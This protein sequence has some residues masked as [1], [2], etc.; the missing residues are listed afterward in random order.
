MS[1]VTMEKGYPTPMGVSIVGKD[2]NI[3]VA[4]TGEECS[5]ILY[6]KATGRKW[7]RLE[8]PGEYRV[9]NV[10]CVL[11]KNFDYS[12]VEY[13]F[14]SEKN[15]FT[16]P[17][18]KKVSG[19]EKWG[20][21]NPKGVFTTDSFDFEDDKPLQ[22]PYEDVILYTLHVRGFTK[23][24]SSKVKHKGTFEGM[25]EKIPYLKDLGIN[26]VE[27]MPAYEFNELIEKKEEKYTLVNIPKDA[28]ESKIFQEEMKIKKPDNKI[29]FWGYT[30]AYYFA[31]KSSYSAVDSPEIS[32][33]HM[34]KEFHKA[35]I[36]IIMQFYFPVE[37]NLNLMIDCIRYWITE[38]HID[39]VHLKGSTVPIE[40]I[41]M[42]PFLS[43]SKISY[44]RMPTEQIYQQNYVPKQRNLAVCDDSYM[45]DIR[46][47]LKSDEDMLRTFI[48]HQLCNPQKHVMV[49][50]LTNY[51]GFTLMDLVSYDR[52]HN[53][54]NGEDNLDGNEYNYS[55]NCGV[56][57]IS[58]RKAI[59]A[60]REKQIKNAFTFLFLSQGVPMIFSGDEFGRTQKGNNNA[61]CQDNEITWINWT[62]FD[63]N[64]EQWE[65]V[66][67]MISF[68]KSHSF[69]HKRE[70]FQMM[71]YKSCGFPDLSY[72]GEMVW[73]PKFEN[74]NR[75]IGL[76]YC[77]DYAELEKGEKDDSFYVAYNM[78]WQSHRFALPKLPKG[79]KWYSFV[80]TKEGFYVESLELKNQA[81][82][83][84]SDRT[85][86]ILIGK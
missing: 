1:D 60:I 86:V 40:M 64:R 41:A 17:Y 25:I 66:K 7:K 72:H 36:E 23:H 71:D 21:R 35:G 67:E 55:W 74:Y 84:V 11:L 3:A 37:K 8:L 2:V 42:D 56:E 76:L 44:E 31:P 62:L 73:Y 38:Y 83:L 16:D 33:K 39:G 46:K 5:M 34:V 52:K 80:T 18:V 9:G 63:K 27:L 82:I 12:Y 29:N 4:V 6:D 26:Q 78:H 49:N 30:D 15:K 77:G 53:D 54:D 69:F 58:R 59:R 75:H 13:N 20:I 14:C 32:F 48:N 22:I 45:Y 68:R 65:F 28:I 19:C 79:K 24:S 50:Y 61:Y 81:D 57:G 47:Y 85:V 51:Y 43:K 10:Y 70:K